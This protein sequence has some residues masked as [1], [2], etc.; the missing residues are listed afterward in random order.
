MATP[1][2]GESPGE[3]RQGMGERTGDLFAVIWIAGEES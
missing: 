2:V 3:E 1:R